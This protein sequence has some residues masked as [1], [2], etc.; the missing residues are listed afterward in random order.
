M[1]QLNSSLDRFDAL[2]KKTTPPAQVCRGLVECCRDTVAVFGKAIGVLALQLKILAS[3]DDDRY[4]RSLILTFYGAT[5][6]I[7]CAWQSMAPHIDAIKPLLSDLRRPSV[8][9]SHTLPLAGNVPSP[10]GPNP[11]SLESP[12][13]HGVPLARPRQPNSLGGTARSR[14]H[15]GSFSSKDVEIGRSLPAY[16]LPAMSSA[17][18]NGMN[19][20]M[21]MVR[22]GPRHPALTSASSTS[23]ASSRLA[24]G[25]NAIRI[26]ASA[27]TGNLISSAQSTNHMRQLS[28]ASLTNSSASSSP[29]MPPN[30]PHA[31]KIPESRTLVDKDALDAMEVAVESAPA[32]WGMM[33]RIVE[34]LRDMPGGSEEVQK[35]I[36]R[37][38]ETTGMLKAHIR[39]IRDGEAGA[40]KRGFREDAHVFVK[41]V[42]KLSN[43]IKMHGSGHEL[44]PALRAKVVELTHATQEFTMLLHV[45]S[46]TPATPRGYSPMTTQTSASPA[47]SVFPPSRLGRAS[48]PVDI[49]L[50]A[51]LSRSRSTQQARSKLMNAPMLHDVPR[52]A[53]P[54]M[55]FNIAQPVAQA[56]ES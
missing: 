33:D 24:G 25:Y 49:R 18:F 52:S 55:S 42:V 20:P 41:A 8:F 31:L 5:A 14:R 4:M 3:K 28:Q 11:A 51:N 21:P 50:G 13:P 44:F 6:E 26:Q 10:D 36:A 12:P 27:S 45:S 2:A 47:T 34:D 15:A 7:S 40:D 43:V 22:T 17:F 46:F 9:R 29:M 35:A 19:G 39:A 38:R 54:H 48:P 30:K 56:Q 1:T 16:D 23:L 32:V 53:L 37:A